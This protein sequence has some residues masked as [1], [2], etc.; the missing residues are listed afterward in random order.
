MED[1]NK[2]LSTVDL[3]TL[4]GTEIENI[5]KLPI[6]KQKVVMLYELYGKLEFVE[7]LGVISKEEV[8]EQKRRV[9]QVLET[10]IVTE[11]SK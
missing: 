2:I 8:L 7:R 11:Y 9:M 6:N 1:T 3:Q 5:Q 4:V 10:D